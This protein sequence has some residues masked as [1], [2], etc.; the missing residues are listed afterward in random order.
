M[1]NSVMIDTHCHLTNEG[2]GPLSGVLERAHASG[3]RRLVT[4]AVTLDDARQ[5]LTVVERETSVWGTVGVHPLDVKEEGIPTIEELSALANH[6]KI[7]ALGE[8]GLDLYHGTQDDLDSQRRSFFNHI[9]VAHALDKAVVIHARQAFPET[10]AL[11]DEAVERYPGVRYI[12]HCFTGDFPTA[13]RFIKKYGCYISFSGIVTFKKGAEDIQKAASNIP[14]AHLL[15]ETDAPFL[16]PDPY[17]GKRNE[18]AWVSYVY[19]A[20]AKLRHTPIHDI[21]SQVDCNAE[22]AFGL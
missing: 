4:I 9:H 20:V 7:V 5:V 2:Y 17:R 13:E 8:T 10:E 19:D 3:V 1:Y 14:L 11:L 12:L 6:P 18:P 16:A 22:K 15:C 21:I